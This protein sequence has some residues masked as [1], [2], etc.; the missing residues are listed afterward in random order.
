MLRPIMPENR[1]SENAV[2]HTRFSDGLSLTAN[3]FFRY[4]PSCQPA[5]SQPAGAPYPRIPPPHP[6]ST[7]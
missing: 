2:P 1:P 3:R 6:R 4:N 7:P 5:P